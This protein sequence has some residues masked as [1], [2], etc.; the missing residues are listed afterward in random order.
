LFLRFAII[1]SSLTFSITITT[2]FDIYTN[3]AVIGKKPS[4]T[5]TNSDCYSR[6]NTLNSLGGGI[7]F[8]TE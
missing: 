5:Y 2:G 8:I 3:N 1:T 7:C 6:G 4:K